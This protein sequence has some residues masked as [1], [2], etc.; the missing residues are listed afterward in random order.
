MNSIATNVLNIFTNRFSAVP[1]M[2]YSPGRINLIGEHIDYNDG[3]VMPAAI[4][5][6]LYYAVAANNTSTINFY[7]ADFNE[8]LSI[9]ISEV[10]NLGG[11][12]SYV[13]S[14]VN[15]F[16]LLG[17]P[18][19]G[20]D[21]VFGGDIPRGSGMSSS[22][23][24]EGGLAFALND[25][26]NCGLT[27]VQLALLC[28]RA[29]H[30]YPGVNCGIMD[31][32]AS[33]NGK[34]GHVI[35]LDCKN[36]THEYFP[37]KLDGYKIVLLNTKVHHTLA[38]GEYN[39][40][41]KRCEEGMVV[42]K[43][44]LNIQ[45][46]REIKSA[47]DVDLHKD[48]MAP[49]VYNCCKFVVEEIARTKTAAALLQQNDLAGFGKLMFA[50]HEG[51]SKLYDVSCAESDFLVALAATNTNI[52]GARQMGGGFGG[53]TINIVKEETID[54]FIEQA[55]AAYKKKFD[56]MPEAYVM[57]VSDGVGKII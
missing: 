14:V 45:S 5:K 7:A 57:E 33:I 2:Y 1:N 47:A 27:R 19:G 17:K 41:R 20:F 44:E 49:E 46:F 35:L 43:K 21:C 11:W 6:G 53:C 13:L 39:V 18:I 42:L 50:T 55:S 10:K 28:Q 40:R 12:K 31:M 36:I 32:Y 51:L 29:E 9:N 48:K 16:V 38:S 37:L 3:Y 8:M 22:A 24:V 15:E 54:S 52:I 30:N 23:A 26:F 56:I 34:K 4:N 25:I